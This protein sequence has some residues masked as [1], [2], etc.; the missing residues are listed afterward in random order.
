MTKADI[1]YLAVSVVVLLAVMVIAISEIIDAER[2][3]GACEYA[4]GKVEGTLCTNGD[5]VLFRE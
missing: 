1:V 2:F 3:S 4:G 5:K